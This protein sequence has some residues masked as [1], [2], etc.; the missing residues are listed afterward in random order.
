MI[1]IIIAMVTMV[2]MVT[3]ISMLTVT[4]SITMVTMVATVTTVTFVILETIIAFTIT[5]AP[6]SRMT[7]IMIIAVITII[8]VRLDSTANEVTSTQDQDKE[9][10]RV[11]SNSTEVELVSAGEGILMR[12]N[13]DVES[14]V[15]PRAKSKDKAASSQTGR[16]TKCPPTT[17]STDNSAITEGDSLEVRHGVTLEPMSPNASSDAR[18][19]SQVNPDNNRNGAPLTKKW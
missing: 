2:T 4:T 11:T 19:D 18:E 13:P 6:N 5:R 7:I 17:I 14:T 8:K 16:D 1:T 9:Q 15:E 10:L 12:V 3:K